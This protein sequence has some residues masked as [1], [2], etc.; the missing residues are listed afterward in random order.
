MDTIIKLADLTIGYQDTIIH[1]NLNINIQTGDFIAIVG[2]NGAGKSTLLKSLAGLLTP[3]KGTI[4]IENEKLYQL[5]PKVKAQKIAIV[6]TEKIT[7]IHLTVF[8]TVAL[9]RQPYSNWLGKLSKDDYIIIEEALKNTDAVD[10]A[11]LK[12]N[13]ISD[14]QKQRVMIARALAQDTPI[15]LLDEPTSH[16]DLAQKINIFN[17]LKKI[18]TDTGKTIIV[19]SH[20]INLSLKKC[21]HFLIID[22]KKHYFN[23]IKQSKKELLA[24]FE[25]SGMKFD[26]ELNQFIY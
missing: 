11:P 9:A 6:L 20:E 7:D 22:N 2:K 8:E 1:K 10:L 14:G 12:I 16:L 13:E 3:L 5:K 26:E 25:S 19:S 21:S 15:V 4:F 17:L 18:N 24:V 23:T